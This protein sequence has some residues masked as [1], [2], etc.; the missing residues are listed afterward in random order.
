MF[1]GR[2]RVRTS[3]TVDIVH[4]LVFMLFTK[5]EYEMRF[6][7]KVHPGIIGDTAVFSYLPPEL[8]ITQRHP[9]CL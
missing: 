5:R 2:R 9:V 3:T 6:R 4:E 1:H 8:L 7:V